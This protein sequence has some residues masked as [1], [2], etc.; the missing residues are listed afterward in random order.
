M[1]YTRK[2]EKESIM[3]QEEFYQHLDILYDA[4]NPEETERFLKF[5]VDL[6]R[7]GET[8][9]RPLLIAALSELGGFY[10]GV[11]RYEE[12]AASFEEAL[13]WIAAVK[14]TDSL[15][16]ATTLNNV[17]GT[18]RQMKDYEKA[19]SCFLK[20][21]DLFESHGETGHYLYSSVLNNLALLY[22]ELGRGEEGMALLT[23][24]M[25]ILKGQPGHEEE[26]ATGILNQAYYYL[27]TEDLVQAE[28]LVRESLAAFEALPY[29][30]T[31]TASALALLA[32][33]LFRQDQTAEAEAMYRR[34]RNTIE[35]TFGKNADYY[36][37]TRSLAVV[38]EAEGKNSEALKLSEEALEILTAILGEDHPAVTQEK[39]TLA[40]TRQRLL[41]S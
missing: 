38:C 5:H 14:G 40:L 32:Q 4:G 31:H 6:Y 28:Q 27:E 17:A 7:D 26:V 34:T 18:Y 35:E 19:E 36:Y 30:S 3:T 21:K 41:L 22:L 12:S 2:S 1:I 9:N 13:Q 15:A 11:S 16:Y 33:L 25:D 20:A 29:K 37:A 23:Q 24:A 10:R 8:V 39:E